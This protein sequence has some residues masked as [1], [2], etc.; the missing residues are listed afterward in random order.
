MAAPSFD[1][2]HA[3]QFDLP[4]GNVRTRRD[5]DR[6]FLIPMAALDELLRS[7]SPPA[8]E[9][10]GRAVGA[11]IGRRVAISLRDPQNASVD[12]FV[13]HLAGEAAIAGLGALSV[14]RWGRALVV[15]IE[16]SPL[17]GALLVAVVASAIEVASGRRARCALLSRD[18]RSSRIF[19]GSE[20]AV[21]RVRAWTA[22]GV[23]WSEAV[24]RLHGGAA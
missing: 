12:A 17:A 5:D 16:N 10:L 7:A 3:V 20:Q 18:D 4:R 24:V 9:A 6:V 8:V 21:D 23:A 19:V 2:T 22:S 14:E 13:V 1:P 15:V 11:A